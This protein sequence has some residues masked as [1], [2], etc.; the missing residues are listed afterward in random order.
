MTQAQLRPNYVARDQKG[1]LAFYVLLWKREGIS[2]ELFDNYW[3]DV[4]GP[5]CARLPGHYQY[6]QFHVAH[7]EGG[8]CP[9][10]AGLSTLRLPEDNFD[11]IAELTFT[12]ESERQIWF[13]SAGILMDDEHNLF[14]KAIGYTT[15]A[16]NSITY[17]DSISQGAPNGES[18]VIKFHVMVKKNP[19]VTLEAFRRYLKE[20]FAAW[21][22]KHESVLKFRLHLFDAVDNSRPDAAGV[23]HSESPESQYHAAYEI[24][25]LN[26]L[27]REKFF[28]SSEYA[29][30]IQE[31]NYYLQQIRP[32][33]ERTAYTFV[34]DGQMTL[35]GQRS[36]KV[37][38]LIA[39]IG[40]ANQ[41]RE[42]ITSLMVS[43]ETQSKGK[44]ESQDQPTLSGLGSLLQGVQHV[45]LTVGDMAKSV[46]FYTEV[47]GG[48]LV[49]SESELTGDVIQNT[50]FQKEELDAIS[51]GLDPRLTDLPRLRSGREDALDVKFISFGNVVVELLLV[52]EALKG[53]TATSSVKNIPS[54]I[55]HV[56]AMHISFNVKEGIDLNEF[57][58]LLEEES[59]KRGLTEVKCN[60]IIHV[61]SEAER[62]AVA[63]KYN[64][65][66][67]WN[68][69]NDE[70][71]M[72]W[73]HDPMEGWSLFYCKGPNGE[74]L[75]F[76]QVTRKVKNN[77]KEAM[78]EYNQ[79]NGT[80]FTFPDSQTSLE[81]G[82]VSGTSSVVSSGTTTLDP[83]F[84]GA[85][86]DLVKR[87]FSRGEAFD[88]EGF[89]TFFTD[90]PVYQFGNFEVCL[91]KAAIKKS[92]D[93]F[94]SQ[95]DAVYHEIKSISE[96]GNVVFVEMDVLYWRKDGSM[97]ALPCSDIFR[98]EGDKFSELR[99]FMDVNPVFN[100]SLRVPASASVLTA[101]RG[102][103]LIP[104][105]TM[106]RHFAE[107]PEGKQRVTQGYIPKWAIAGP[108]WAIT[109]PNDNSSEQLKVVQELSGAIMA[110]D[111]EK[112]KTYLT[113]DLFYK[114]G[115]GEPMYGPSSVVEFFKHTFR[116]TAKFSGHDARKVSIEP[117][118]ITIEMD[119]YYDLVP[120]RKRV[121]VACCDIYRLRGLKV[122]EWRVYAD[123]TPWQV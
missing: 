3:K 26:H 98:V 104:P 101:S 59:R 45:G 79:A 119:A 106:R 110:E 28:S 42:D 41:L 96:V 43:G 123:M 14:R 29:G 12:S 100:P 37:A 107:H 114:V 18:G 53:D 13:E 27:E 15:S 83:K 47:L 73:S 33:P 30:A 6:W 90:N 122:S 118:I 19:G 70:A 95:I 67:F 64:S 86:T 44:P 38:D 84:P 91:D 61:T 66:K 116:T 9:T 120:S 78:Q 60:R 51:Q 102:Q 58:Q 4:H 55:G 35:A 24:A 71:P 111:W 89:I 46:Q 5:V 10:I 85:N 76:N 115:S 109:T 92:A 16:G 23:V 57:A 74:Q 121:T 68:E 31:A 65:F 34:Y 49:V 21:V 22:I 69:P 2:L 25:F 113:D 117:N 112:V 105:G 17:I 20:T 80:A 77:F 75:E 87:L 54:H 1:K 72:D 62:K 40:A 48:K 32:F 50:L 56:N 8:F 36:A 97:I 39:Q 7:D 11:G 82:K 99:I 108:K 52:R 93:N 63:L 94:F 103:K 88:S 81:N